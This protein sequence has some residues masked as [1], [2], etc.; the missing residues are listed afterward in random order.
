MSERT[1][2]RRL[3]SAGMKACRPA[4]KPM[5]TTQH[6]LNR[7]IWAQEIMRWT[8]EQWASALFFFSDETFEVGLTGHNVLEVQCY[9]KPNERSL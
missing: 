8:R 6:K 5:L 3:A 9:R 4:V 2:V 7:L 1:V